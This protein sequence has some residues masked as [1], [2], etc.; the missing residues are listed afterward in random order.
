[1]IGVTASAGAQLDFS[2]MTSDSYTSGKATYYGYAPGQSAGSF[3]NTSIEHGDGSVHT[4]TTFIDEGSVIRM[5]FNT[6]PSVANSDS[7]SFNRIVVTNPSS[8]DGLVLDRST[9]YVTATNY[10]FTT[11]NAT[12]QNAA[13]NSH[14]LIV[15]FRAD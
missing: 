9:G 15:E 2:I 7:A 13:T 6:S 12:L 8:T 3:S 5:T 4:V 11:S 1:M 14:T 10:G